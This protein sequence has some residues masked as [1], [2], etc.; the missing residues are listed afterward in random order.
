MRARRGQRLQHFAEDVHAAVIRLGER[1]A[2][3]RLVDALDLDV[4]LDGGD[5][6]WVP[7]TLKSISPR[8]S[9][10]PWMSVSTATLPVFS[11]SLIRP[12]ATPATGRLIGTPA[13]ISASVEPQT[14]ACEV[15]PLEDMTSL[16]RRSA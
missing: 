10:K 8:K 1:L 16:T 12:M 14:E 5:A 11:T 13:S 6:L 2:Q 7:A 9:S 4:H 3:D 15:E